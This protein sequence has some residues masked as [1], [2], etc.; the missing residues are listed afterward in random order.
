[1]STYVG[2]TEK[3]EMI[4]FNVVLEGRRERGTKCGNNGDTP[5]NGKGHQGPLVPPRAK[6][7]AWTF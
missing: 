2:T 3:V 1:M 5:A 6:P 7:F 4:R